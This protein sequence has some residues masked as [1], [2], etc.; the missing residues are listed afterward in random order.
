MTDDDRITYVDRDPVIPTHLGTDAPHVHHRGSDRCLRAPDGVPCPTPAELRAE[1]E[2][3]TGVIAD[4]LGEYALFGRSKDGDSTLTG[5][6]AADMGAYAQRL[7]AQRDDA[8][9]RALAFAAERDALQQQVANVQALADDLEAGQGPMLEWNVPVATT[10]AGLIRAALGGPAAPTPEPTITGYDGFG[11]PIMDH[12]Q[13]PQPT[14]D[15]RDPRTRPSPSCYDPQCPTDSACLSCVHKDA[16]PEPTPAGTWTQAEVDAIQQRAADRFE[17]MDPLVEPVERIT[18]DR[19]D[20]LEHG[21]HEPGECSVCDAARQ[22]GGG[23]ETPTYDRCPTCRHL[24]HPSGT[25]FN[26]ASDN[27]CSCRDTRSETVPR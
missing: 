8:I 24:P 26:M 3:L 5:D 6:L 27:D 17:R 22:Q 20:E 4:R 13:E 7:K 21:E 2:R 1:V 25:C 16:T 11:A 23:E 10:Y 9:A 19:G 14:G 12:A 15:P 18:D